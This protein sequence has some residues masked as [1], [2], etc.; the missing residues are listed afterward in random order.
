VISFTDHYPDGVFDPVD[1]LASQSQALW[2]RVEDMLCHCTTPIERDVVLG[3]ADAIEDGQSANSIYLTLDYS[4]Q[5]IIAAWKSL[6]AHYHKVL[7]DR[8]E[9]LPGKPGGNQRRPSRGHGGSK[10]AA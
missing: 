2:E 1:H 3:I 10:Q 4:Q 6:A 5:E 9:S 7:G 8:G